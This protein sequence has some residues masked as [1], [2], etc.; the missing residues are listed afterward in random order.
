MP[1]L[2]EKH[3]RRD[4]E[5]KNK[6]PVLRL[7]SDDKGARENGCEGKGEMIKKRKR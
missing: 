2:P 1:E 3:K 4:P 6:V 7:P 5:G